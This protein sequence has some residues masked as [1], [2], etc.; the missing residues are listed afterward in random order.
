MLLDKL[1]ALHFLAYS[2]CADILLQRSLQKPRAFAPMP[3]SMY[4][5]PS[6]SLAAALFSR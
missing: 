1:S 3:K 4:S 5:F 2:Q 6:K